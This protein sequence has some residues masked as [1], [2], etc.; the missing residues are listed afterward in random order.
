M[1]EC[2]DQVSVLGEGGRP[3]AFVVPTVVLVVGW[4]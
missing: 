1:L 2:V 4:D 3:A